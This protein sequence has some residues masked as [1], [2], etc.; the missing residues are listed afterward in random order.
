MHIARSV[1]TYL[2]D[3]RGTVCYFVDPCWHMPLHEAASK[4]LELGKLRC[5]MQEQQERAWVMEFE[6]KFH[7]LP[8]AW[9]AVVLTVG[10]PCRMMSGRSRAM[11]RRRGT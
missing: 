8:K 7:N 4:F 5:S 9:Q 2:L 6:M 3:A 10:W 11:E 1:R